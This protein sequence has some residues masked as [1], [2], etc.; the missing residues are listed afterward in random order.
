MRNL[1]RRI[2]LSAAI[3]TLAS[4]ITVAPTYA[5]LCS[6]S[7]EVVNTF[8]SGAVMIRLD[9]AAVN[10]KGQADDTKDRVTS[11]QYKYVA[12][13]VLDQDPT[14]TVEA[15]SEESYI[16]MSV[17]NELPDSFSIDWNT[18]AWEKVE[19]EGNTSLWMRKSTVDASGSDK[20]VTLEPIF[21]EVKVPTSLTGDQAKEL[22][23]R[24]IHVKAFAIQKEGLSKDEAI[25]EAKNK[26]FYGISTSTPETGKD[27]ETETETTKE[28]TV[29]ETVT[30]TTTTNPVSE[31]VKDE[32]TVTEET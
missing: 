19:T 16:F 13:A 27:E 15:G 29:T 32:K 14:V 2:A 24:T 30:E 23:G 25:K 11:N 9:E 7:E 18:T 1:K 12:G 28:T 26:L 17:L 31:A 4:V 10:S 21:T 22:D 20:D 5:W 3:V 8:V 6:T